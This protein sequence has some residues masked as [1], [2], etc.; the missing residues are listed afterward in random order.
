MRLADLLQSKVDRIE[1]NTEVAAVAA[2]ETN[3]LLSRIAKSLEATSGAFGSPHVPD[4]TPP[5][6]SQKE[7]ME[8]EESGREQEEREEKWHERMLSK[9]QD[10][11]KNLKENPDGIFGT[12][13]K[14]GA[15]LMLLLGSYLFP[16]FVNLVTKVLPTISAV[17]GW[18]FRTVSGIGE[19]IGKAIGAIIPGI[20][21]GVAGAVGAIA[22]LGAAIWIVLNPLKALTGVIK[23]AIGAVAL[24]KKVVAMVSAD[25]VGGASGGVVPGGEDGKNK[26]GGRQG[27]QGRQGRGALARRPRP[28]VADK[29][30]VARTAATGVSG[31]VVASGATPV[32]GG[33]A[34]A[35]RLGL[36]AL[37]V[38][39]TAAAVGLGTYGAYTSW[40]DAAAAQA[41]GDISAAEAAEAKGGAVG[42]G[43]GGIGGALG[44]AA[45]G[46]SI[47][48]VVPVAGTIVGGAVGGLLGYFGG[49]WA[50]SKAGEAA[51][52]MVGAPNEPAPVVPP[53]AP[54][55]WRTEQLSAEDVANRQE[56]FLLRAFKAQVD[57]LLR[58]SRITP[59]I[60][61]TV[62]SLRQEQTTQNAFKAAPGSYATPT[63]RRPPRSSGGALPTPFDFDSSLGSV[64]KKFESGGRGPGTIS[65]GVGD[66]GGISYGSFQISSNAGTMASFLERSRYAGEFAGMQINSQE[67]KDRW[68]EIAARDPEG[69]YADQHA[70]IKE[71][72]FDPAARL[73]LN[74]LGIDVGRRGRAFQEM[75]WSTAVQFGPRRAVNL[76]GN[77][78]LHS[79][80]SDAEAIKAVQGHKKANNAT[81]FKSSSANMREGTLAR[82]TKEKMAL[83]AVADQ[84][85]AGLAGLSRSAGSALSTATSAASTA[86]GGGVTIVSAPVTNAPTTVVGG[87][88][89]AMQQTPR[90]VTTPPAV[91]T[92]DVGAIA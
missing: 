87:Q 56:E 37:P 79:G 73:L 57:H 13:G 50:G 33:L 45:L 59:L 70:F 12:L 81:L 34:N 67:F 6:S 31:P 38:V 44:G 78:G 35:G 24:F 11:N 27:R 77:A 61:Q 48:S 71:T 9:L 74:E 39:G 26:K 76:L 63:T 66:H 3:E 10:I 75:L 30:P 43:V 22:G 28:T 60:V 21:A 25:A 68:R 49:S 17:F 47:G 65:T 83:L 62:E 58:R 92:Y 64:S 80:M 88:A 84:S 14:I 69:F 53:P 18:L 51:G 29:K 36:R 19:Q 16:F 90:R 15:A 89:N 52:R 7:Q 1:G 40:Q 5:I 54:S 82:A 91:V 8:D 41:A 86:A 23:G 32:T 42:T 55:M 72:H 46:A 4:P 2:L 20:D 85:S